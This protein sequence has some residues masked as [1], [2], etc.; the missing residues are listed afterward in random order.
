MAK[1]T[2]TKTKAEKEESEGPS[3]K[4]I[5]SSFMTEHKDDHFNDVVPLHKVIS[6]GSLL[7]DQHVKIRSGGVVRLSGLGA[8]LG[9]TSESLVLLS[10]YMS[11]MPKS[12]GIYFKA[13]GRLS[14]EMKIRSGMKFVENPAEWEYGTTFVFCGNKFEVVAQLIENL[15]KDMHD[16]GEHLGII[17]DSLDG[18]ILRADADKDVWGGKESPKVAGVPLLT[19]LLFRRIALP[20]THYDALMMIT[21]QYSAPISLD[22]YAPAAPRQISGGGG[23]SAMHQSDY[24]F[25]LGQRYMGDYILE[26]PDEKPDVKSNQIVGVW[27][28]YHIKKSGTDSS[29]I[30]IKIPIKKGRV[31]SAIW[32][33]KE[34]VDMILMFNLAKRSGAWFTFEEAFVNEAKEAGVTLKEK[35]QGLNGLYAYVESEKP[36]FDWLLTKF[37]GLLS[38]SQTD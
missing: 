23:S 9:K 38:I 34:V 21:S 12:K 7:L 3:S 2:P 32:V 10:N 17:I 25:E 33:E 5:L 30:K 27:A 11:V 35:V 36:V 1:S 19:K 16:K 6:T 14:D 29:G 4:D 31:G 22:P 15:L 26:K 8:E 18:L 28:T 20:V 13:E 24:V 37:K